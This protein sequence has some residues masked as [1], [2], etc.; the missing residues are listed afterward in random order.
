MKMPNYQDRNKWMIN[1]ECDTIRYLQT[2]KTLLK[3]NFV[4]EKIHDINHRKQ[5]KVC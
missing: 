5:P 1:T 3:L 2:Y 4:I